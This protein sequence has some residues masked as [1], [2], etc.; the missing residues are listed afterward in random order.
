M[1]KWQLNVVFM[2][3]CW[4]FIKYVLLLKDF[5]ILCS[6]WWICMFLLQYLFGSVLDHLVWSWLFIPLLVVCIYKYIYIY[7]Y[8]SMSKM[9]YNE[10]AQWLNRP[11]YLFR[12]SNKYKLYI[13]QLQVSRMSRII[14]WIKILQIFLQDT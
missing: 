10:S 12:S 1:N 8:K 14:R 9:S 5:S 3:Y 2:F 7:I 11:I 13:S 4:M 6:F